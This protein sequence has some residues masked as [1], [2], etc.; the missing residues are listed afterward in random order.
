MNNREQIENVKTQ[1]IEKITDNMNAF[2]VS[3]SVG[4]V[5]GIIYMNREPMT[6]DELSAETGMSKTRM[7]QVVREM[8]DMNIAE[9]VFKKGVRK[10]LYQVEEDYYQT[11]ISLFIFTWQ[12]AINRSRNFEQRL[13]QKLDT[14]QLESDVAEE[15]EQAINELLHE[16]REWM[17]YYDWIQR[18]TEFFASGEIFEH[19]PKKK[20]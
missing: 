5:L 14:L 18:V 16:I 13:I 10:D 15:D 11:F 3:T 12:K 20:T 7:S 19:V 17:D 1:F 2:G 8:I 9:R 6:L 4:R